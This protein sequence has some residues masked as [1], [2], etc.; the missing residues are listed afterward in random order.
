MSNTDDMESV[1]NVR[2]ELVK[3]GFLQCRKRNTAFDAKD[4]WIASCWIG[5]IVLLSVIL[6]GISIFLGSQLPGVE[7][8]VFAFSIGTPMLSPILPILALFLSLA[9][10]RLKTFY[11]I[12]GVSM[13]MVGG[14]SNI[15]ER[16]TTGHVDDFLNFFGLWSFNL[17]DILIS[18]GAFVI[19]LGLIWKPKR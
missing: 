6:F 14:V 19:I 2:E 17:A 16:L 18:F 11:S 7:N 13:V 8:E 12:I 5:I 10:L 9:L 1:T 3:N 4:L 15:L